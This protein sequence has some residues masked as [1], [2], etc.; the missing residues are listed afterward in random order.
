MELLIKTKKSKSFAFSDWKLNDVRKSYR[1]QMQLVIIFYP[2]TILE[3][4]PLYWGES[5][6]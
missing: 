1:I 6:D 3:F 2:A 5:I 4:I